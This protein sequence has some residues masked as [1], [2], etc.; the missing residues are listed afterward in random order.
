VL[1]FDEGG[2]GDRG[3][4]HIHLFFADTGDNMNLKPN[5][6]REKKIPTR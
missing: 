3:Q 2:C 4:S 1:A 5:A 6:I